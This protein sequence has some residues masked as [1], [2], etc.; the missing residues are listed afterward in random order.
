M[1][2]V[3]KREDR[4]GRICDEIMRGP[5][6]P[7]PLTTASWTILAGRYVSE[8]GTTLYCMFTAI[9]RSST[10]YYYYVMY[11]YYYSS[12]TIQVCR[13]NSHKV[14]RTREK[15]LRCD[16]I[17]SVRYLWTLPDSLIPGTSIYCLCKRAAAAASSSDSGAAGRYNF[18]EIW[19]RP[20]IL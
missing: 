5:S 20:G 15:P 18:Q 7:L 10:R 14:F 2:A 6:T 8:L 12:Y 3:D 9:S 13:K 1:Q 17:S 11:V 4:P 16:L 19:Q